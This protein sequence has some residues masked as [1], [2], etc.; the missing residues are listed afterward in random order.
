MQ[1]L[2]DESA[3]AFEREFGA[4]ARARTRETAVGHTGSDGFLRVARSG[5]G[6]DAPDIES[7]R[8]AEVEALLGLEPSVGALVGGFTLGAAAGALATG[9]LVPALPAL[10]FGA[11]L[12]A[13]AGVL[14]ISLWASGTRAI[15]LTS[16]S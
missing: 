13:Y 12:G 7:A 2:L 15:R 4:A 3:L 5:L 11:A 6:A 10:A 8:Q 9:L 1:S 16:R 14:A